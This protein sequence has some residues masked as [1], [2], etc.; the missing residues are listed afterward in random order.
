MI[1]GGAEAAA[2]FELGRVLREGR[3]ACGRDVHD[4]GGA[5]HAWQHG[6][7]EG[8]RRV[9]KMIALI[10]AAGLSEIMHG[11]PLRYRIY[12]RATGAR[13]SIAVASAASTSCGR[14]VSSG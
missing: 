9:Q 6:A 3:A 12:H 2:G 5:L 13:N 4:G 1:G 11:R 7:D 8:V 14:T 10:G